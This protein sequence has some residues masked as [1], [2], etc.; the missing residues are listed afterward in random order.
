[1]PQKQI[2]LSFKD[3]FYE[4]GKLYHKLREKKPKQKL[5][6]SLVPKQ[7]KKKTF[8]LLENNSRII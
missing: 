2:K 3:K 6:T 5:L 1:M 4:Q 8:L 7:N